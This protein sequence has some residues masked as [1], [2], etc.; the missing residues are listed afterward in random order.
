MGDGDNEGN[1]IA[2]APT[3]NDEIG[4]NNATWTIILITV[5]YPNQPR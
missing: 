2:T 4:S 5:L 1:P 3:I